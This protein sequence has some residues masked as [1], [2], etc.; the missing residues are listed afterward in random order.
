MASRAFPSRSGSGT[1]RV[2]A[3]RRGF[4]LIELLA[5]TAIITLISAVILVDNNRFGGTVLLENLAYQVGLSIRQ[6]QVYG[7]AVAR[8]GTGE[9]AFSNGYGMHF[10][11]SNPNT[12]VLFADAV[13]ENGIWDCPTPGSPLTCETV[14]AQTITI[15][16]G[17]SIYDLCITPGAGQSEICN[18]ASDSESVGSITRIDILFKR[19]EPDAYISY[20]GTATFTGNDVIPNALNESARIVLASPRGDI[21]S[22]VVDNTGQIYIK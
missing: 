20:N 4:T 5:V 8:F 3:L 6:A 9:N 16:R 11:L 7:I 18:R 22:V 15:Q 21:K 2:S 1:L 13:T 10:D 17:Y 19:P 14:P 12:Y